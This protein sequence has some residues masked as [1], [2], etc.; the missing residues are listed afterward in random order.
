MNIGNKYIVNLTGCYSERTTAILPWTTTARGATKI[1]INDWVISYGILERLLTDK[2][3]QFV[4]NFMNSASGALGTKLMTT[5][6]YQPQTSGQNKRYNKTNGGRLRRYIGEHQSDWD[7][8]F[9]LLMYAYNAP[10]HS[11]ANET[12]FGSELMRKVWTA[13]RTRPPSAV[14]STQS[15][16]LASQKSRSAL[17]HRTSPIR[18][19]TSAAT[20]K[21]HKRYEMNYDKMVQQVLVYNKNDLV[22]L[23]DSS[24]KRDE[25]STY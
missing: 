17:F 18:A 8:F 3:P 5:P 11:T 19:T 21:A 24:P 12:L 23:R 2:E 1:F 16:P 6:A 10:N 14:L 4:K 13:Y 25:N 9:Q 15:E 22:Y 7:N 20:G